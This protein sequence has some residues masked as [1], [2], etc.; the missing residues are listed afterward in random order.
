[1]TDVANSGVGRRMNKFRELLE[2]VLVMSVDSFKFA[3][4]H[5][6]YPDLV[7]KHGNTLQQICIQFLQCLRANVEVRIESCV[8]LSLV[9]CSLLIFWVKGICL[10]TAIASVDILF[11]WSN[12]TN[13]RQLESSTN[14]QNNLI[15][16]TG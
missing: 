1:M 10:K 3:N 2:K 12:R 5:A 13:L 11:V 15:V 6:C 8:V 7:D 14:W 4:M 9:C 16:W